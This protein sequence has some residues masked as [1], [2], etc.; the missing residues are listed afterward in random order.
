MTRLS[1]AFDLSKIAIA[2]LAFILATS[3]V[4]DLRRDWLSPFSL[5]K[6]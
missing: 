2:I 3:K 1:V 5:W 4:S 6:L